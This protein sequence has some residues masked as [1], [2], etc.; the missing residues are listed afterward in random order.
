MS[1]PDDGAL[2]AQLDALIN[3]A[4][5]CIADIRQAKQTGGLNAAPTGEITLHLQR[6]LSSLNR[7]HDLLQDGENVYYIEEDSGTEDF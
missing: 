7:I 4:L 1:E 6:C 3:Q 2:R 5:R